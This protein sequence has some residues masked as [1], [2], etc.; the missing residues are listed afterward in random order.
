MALFLLAEHRNS[1]PQSWLTAPPPK[2]KKIE[3][4]GPYWS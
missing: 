4:D 1:E 2:K 3:H